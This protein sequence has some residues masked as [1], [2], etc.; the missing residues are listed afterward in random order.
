MSAFTLDRYLKMALRDADGDVAC[1]TPI[2]IEHSNLSCVDGSL[3]ASPFFVI[4][5]L[6]EAVL[7]SAC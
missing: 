1:W 4:V 2:E 5:D 6:S 3:F 7:C